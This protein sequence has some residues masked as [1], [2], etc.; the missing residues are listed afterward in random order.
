MH[1]YPRLKKSPSKP[2]LN[3]KNLQSKRP[4]PRS[5]LQQIEQQQILLQ[6]Q[7]KDQLEKLRIPNPLPSQDTIETPI[8]EK[9]SQPFEISSTE[10]TSSVE[11]EAIPSPSDEEPS[12]PGEKISEN[13]ISD[14]PSSLE[15]IDSPT[16][17]PVEPELHC[18]NSETLFQNQIN[19]N[20]IEED[21][22]T[23]EPPVEE[24][25][26]QK[27]NLT[28]LNKQANKQTN[29]QSENKSTPPQEKSNENKRKSIG[30]EST[31]EVQKKSQN[32]ILT[33]KKSKNLK[34]PNNKM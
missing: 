2:I 17:P 28:K 22:S 34:I 25:L 9:I 13:M 7:H 1:L 14:P 24:S 31:K 32:E 26:P 15:T 20:P 27:R 4:N 11:E 12:F 6:Q 29:K 8:N 3:N 18:D 5:L 33:Q 23:F 10:Q 19:E 16:T 30:E 21:L